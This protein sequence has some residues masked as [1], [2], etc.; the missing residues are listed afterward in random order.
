ME[1]SSVT[2]QTRVFVALGLAGFL[3][4]LS[5]AIVDSFPVQDGD[6]YSRFAAALAI[7]VKVEVIRRLPIPRAPPDMPSV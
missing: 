3:C 4:A 6:G 2:K 7:V 1:S 5:E